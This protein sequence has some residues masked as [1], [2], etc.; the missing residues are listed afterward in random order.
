MHAAEFSPVRIVALSE[1]DNDRRL[2]GS[3]SAHRAQAPCADKPENRLEYG[4]GQT[5]VRYHNTTYERQSIDG[6]QR[7]GG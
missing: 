6:P 3:C 7:W 5:S 1:A 2:V 4:H